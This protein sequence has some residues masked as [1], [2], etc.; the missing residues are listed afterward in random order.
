[1]LI[2]I[3]GPAGAGKSTV[4]RALAA[5]LAF[6]YLDTG[7]MYRCVGLLWLDRP[8]GPPAEIAR[9]ARIEFVAEAG[10]SASA[11]RV[12]LD[13]RDVGE[14]I[15]KAE[16]SEA[17][18]RVAADADVR[19]AL[20]ARQREMIAAGNWVAEG[21]DIAT[22]VAPDAELKVYL[23]AAAQERA[24][25]RASELGGD[26]QTI[27]AEQALRDQRDSGF[28][29]ST[30]APAPGAVELDTTGLTIEQVVERIAAMAAELRPTLQD[31]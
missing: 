27:M 23:T 7:A 30:L 5:R 29:R 28:G 15:R 18:S 16:V 31:V 20:V 10:P 9:S 25:R 13:G 3:D 6:T 24:R 14:A 11:P 1:M 12:L 19:E 21:R 2:A 22:V 4:A 17:A 8:D 26:R